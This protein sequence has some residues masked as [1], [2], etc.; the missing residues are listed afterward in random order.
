MLVPR[1]SDS[2][3][4]CVCDSD[5]RCHLSFSVAYDDWLKGV[6]MDQGNL[7]EQEEGFHLRTSRQHDGHEL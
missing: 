4:G 1:D 7:K 5:K 6:G 2:V 3:Q